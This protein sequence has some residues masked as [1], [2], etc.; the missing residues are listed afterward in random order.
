MINKIKMKYYFLNIN[1]I[2]RGCSMKRDFE[3]INARFE[4]GSKNRIEKVIEEYNRKFN[5][6]I[7]LSISTFI[8]VAVNDLLKTVDREGIEYLNNLIRENI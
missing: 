5:P 7:K 8:R 1:S 3:L 4:A 6:V 2:E